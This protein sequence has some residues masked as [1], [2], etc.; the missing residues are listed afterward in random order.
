LICSQPLNS[1]VFLEVVKVDDLLS[2]ISKV[3]KVGSEEFESCLVNFF[4]FFSEID[5]I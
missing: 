2:M 3:T 4:F 1:L 5:L